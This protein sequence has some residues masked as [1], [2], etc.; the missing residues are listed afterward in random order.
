[1]FKMRLDIEWINIYDNIVHIKCMGRRVFIKM[2]YLYWSDVLVPQ[3][4]ANVEKDHW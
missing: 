3:G 1:M 2:G 4:K